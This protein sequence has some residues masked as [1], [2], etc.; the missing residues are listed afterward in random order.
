MAPNLDRRGPR[1]R[2]LDWL[3]LRRHRPQSAPE[4]LVLAFVSGKGGTGKSF[5]ATNFAIALYRQGLRTC[6]V[7]C[8]FGLGNAHLLF[9]MNPKLT[10][11]HLLGRQARIEDVVQPT[12]HGPS[13]VAGGSGIR[14][15]CEIDDDRLQLFGSS[16]A[17]LAARNDVLV[18]DGPAGLSAQ[19]LMTALV[20]TDVVLVTN[21]EIAALTD[22]YAL[23]K[24]L[25]RHDPSPA[26]HVAVNRVSDPG[27][28]RAT[29]ERLA[30]VARR[31]A[32]RQIHY[33]GAI[34][35]DSAVTQRR[36]GQP[37][38]ILSHPQCRTSL[39]VVEMIETLR[40][41]IGP[42]VPRARGQDLEQRVRASLRSG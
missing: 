1:P 36:L 24:C 16:L 23:I 25:S 19:S 18:L 8:D 20:A 13:L 15:L 33:A 27:L 22:A 31:F 26:V 7:D 30:D 35:E 10:V 29:F 12:P 17:W 40:R 42:L 21:P 2:C 6:V 5:L 34:P 9:G 14:G 28:G 32:G 37:P 4:A 41:R 3:L 39:A 11:Q 38:L